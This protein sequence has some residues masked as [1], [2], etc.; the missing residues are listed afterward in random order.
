MNNQPIFY[1]DQIRHFFGSEFTGKIH[2]NKILINISYPKLTAIK[3]INYYSIFN[4]VLQI[5]IKT[6]C[7][8][9]WFWHHS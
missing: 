4:I 5:C 3:I 6:K 9:S 1:I 8:R 2:P 7:W